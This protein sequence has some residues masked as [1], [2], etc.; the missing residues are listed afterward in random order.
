[1][2]RSAAWDRSPCW[3]AAA[4]RVRSGA[5]HRRDKPRTPGQGQH[6]DQSATALCAFP[7]STLSPASI[8][9]AREAGGKPVS[10]CRRSV[11]RGGAFAR[12]RSGHSVG[13]SRYRCV[14]RSSEQKRQFTLSL[15]VSPFVPAA[16]AHGRFQQTCAA[17]GGGLRVAGA[18]ARRGGSRARRSRRRRRRR[19]P[20]RNGAF[21]SR[22]CALHLRHCVGTY[23]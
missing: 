4:R 19:R 10:S 16:F 7:L 2:S 9:E 21:S 18:G 8:C 12:R 11:F 13:S 22:R 17:N 20:R 1:M 5:Q 3:A 14:A 23:V 15:T 6:S